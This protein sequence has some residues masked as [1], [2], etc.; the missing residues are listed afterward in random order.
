MDDAGA[1]PY[2][3]GVT[4]LLLL[5]ALLSA[6]TG[7]GPDV[8]APQA[9]VAISRAAE[10]VVAPAT[11]PAQVSGAPVA[12]LPKP[13]DLAVLPARPAWRLAPAAPLYL[14]RRRE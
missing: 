5:S 11:R 3:G 4:L 14:S 7:A 6:L 12:A 13:V 10:S 8:R 2:V 9:A 1:R